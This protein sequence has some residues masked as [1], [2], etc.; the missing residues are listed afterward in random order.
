M[1]CKYYAVAFACISFTEKLFPSDL[2]AED[3]FVVRKA[4]TIPLLADLA[5]VD[6]SSVPKSD[7]M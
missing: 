1:R 7:F 2:P 6:I 4:R 5:K 3:V